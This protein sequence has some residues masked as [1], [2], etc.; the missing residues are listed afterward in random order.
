VR[1]RTTRRDPAATPAPDLV[2]RRFQAAGLD[3]LWVAD[4]TYWPTEPEGFLYR[5]V[6]LD[7]FSPRGVGWS[8]QEQLHTELVLAALEMAVSKR[9]PPPGLIHHSDHRGQY[10]SG[11]FGER[12][13][14]SGI[15]SQGGNGRRLLRQRLDGELFRYLGVRALGPAPLPDP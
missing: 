12:C 6:I 10:P 11:R 1:V 3:R 8:M 14:A 2:E 9:Q 4:I 5:S 15:H 13:A 7:V